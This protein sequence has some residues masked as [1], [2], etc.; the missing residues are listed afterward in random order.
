M[1]R[2]NILEARRVTSYNDGYIEIYDIEDQ[3]SGDFPERRI[4]KRD[5]A[6]VWFRQLAV[7]D[8]T[9]ITFEQ[10]D[11]VITRKVAIPQWWDGISSGCVVMLN[12]TGA[13]EKVFNVAQ[14][15]NKA[16]LP[17]TELTLINPEMPYEEVKDDDHKN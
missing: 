16:G 11:K 1:R 8:R 12:G 2:T 5:M 13:Q 6:P 15:Y 9:R 4:R 14:V 7:Y 10:A 17:E 3:A